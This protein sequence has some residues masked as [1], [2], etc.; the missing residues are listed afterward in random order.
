MLFR[1]CATSYRR[2]KNGSNKRRRLTGCFVGE[3]GL[4]ILLL[5]LSFAGTGRA[6]TPVVF[7]VPQVTLDGTVAL[8]AVSAAEAAEAA[9][10]VTAA[11]VI[12]A[13]NPQDRGMGGTKGVASKFHYP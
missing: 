5:A 8:V 7:F 12:L 4:D 2:R 10:I 11:G 1:Y 6:G 13:A 3:Y 9:K